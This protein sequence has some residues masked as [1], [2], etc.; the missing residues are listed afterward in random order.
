MHRP[1]LSRPAPQNARKHMC[2]A[3]ATCGC[4][5]D[6]EE[7]AGSRKSSLASPHATAAVCV[8]DDGAAVKEETA[9]A[10]G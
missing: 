3:S 7:S 8:A 10:D 6:F 2:Q 1:G 4:P 5:A 9:P